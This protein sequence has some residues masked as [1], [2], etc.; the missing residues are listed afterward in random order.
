[1]FLDEGVPRSVGRLFE[2]N[3]HTVIYL[4]QAV[5]R[6]SSDPIVATA[7]QANACI[8]VA[9]DGDMREIAKKNGVSN[10]RYKK[11]SLI[12]LS[13][14]E[15]QAANRVLQFLAL[16]ESEWKISTEKSARRLFID[17]SDSRITIHR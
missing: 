9:L 5:D 7:A 16:I 17:I 15:T 10:S 8:L 6:G 12:K 1:L 13:C 3:G 4:E 2:S 11:L 14:N